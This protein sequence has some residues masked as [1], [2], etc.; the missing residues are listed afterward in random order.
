[1]SKSRSYLDDDE[2]TD[3][4]YD[5]DR[6][7][8]EYRARTGTLSP[9]GTH[10][11]PMGHQ[12]PATEPRVKKRRT[13]V[14]DGGPDMY[15]V[16][17]QR[18]RKNWHSHSRALSFGLRSKHVRCHLLQGACLKLCYTHA[19]SGAGRRAISPNGGFRHAC[20]F[21][22]CARRQSLH[23][24]AEFGGELR[25]GTKGVG[26]NGACESQMAASDFWL[27]FLQPRC[28]PKHQMCC[29]TPPL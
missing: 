13:R 6:T 19:C 8:V 22:L 16:A 9:Y 12:R 20:R 11:K 1:M 15:N 21:D 25:Q 27:C 26:P 10:Y 3:R 14:D 4:D 23:P 2:M 18:D 7:S 17:K 28:S 5:A 29:M 24:S